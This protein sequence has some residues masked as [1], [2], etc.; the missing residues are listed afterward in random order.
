MS[1]SR[2]F[3]SLARL[4]KLFGQ[5]RYS[6]A[7]F[8]LPEQMARVKCNTLLPSLMICFFVQAVNVLTL[9]VMLIL[10]HKG[11]ESLGITNILSTCAE[12]IVALRF[13]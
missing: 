13:L 9:Q 10:P 6:C 12:A 8:H 7:V 1:Q 2:N 4:I 11:V 3:A 5:I